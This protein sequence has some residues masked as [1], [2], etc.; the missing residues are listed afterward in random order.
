M[1]EAKEAAEAAAVGA[2]AA[3]ATAPLVAAA[4]AVFLFLGPPPREFLQELSRVLFREFS[5]DVTP[6]SNISSSLILISCL[7]LRTIITLK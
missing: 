1:E 4:A 7:I 6:S 5:Y 2:T 3:A